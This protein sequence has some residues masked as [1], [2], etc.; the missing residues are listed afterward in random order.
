MPSAAIEN[1]RYYSLEEELQAYE[2][3]I[4]AILESIADDWGGVNILREAAEEEVEEA[5]KTLDEYNN[6]RERRDD[7][8]KQIRGFQ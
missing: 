1:A 6:L 4:R 2:S 7:I 5:R 8:A 3:A